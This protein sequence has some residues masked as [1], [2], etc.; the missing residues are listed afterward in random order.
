MKIFLHCHFTATF[1]VPAIP[2]QAGNGGPE[3]EFP[4]WPSAPAINPGNH[5]LHDPGMS[6]HTDYSQNVTDYFQL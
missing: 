3:D 1:S 6:G 2:S 5:W 4:S